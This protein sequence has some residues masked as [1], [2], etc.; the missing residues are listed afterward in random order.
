[1]AV[2]KAGG[3]WCSNTHQ[4]NEAGQVSIYQEIVEP[5]L[6]VSFFPAFIPEPPSFFTAIWMKFSIYIQQII[7]FYI[8][9]Q[10][11]ARIM[12]DRVGFCVTH[13][14]KISVHAQ[15]PVSANHDMVV[16][17]VVQN[18]EDAVLEEVWVVSLR[19]CIY[20]IRNN[21]DI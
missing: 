19:R 12:S 15:V 6:F 18:R 4:L 9:M 16:F 8:F 20:S 3:E 2:I 21:N 13:V 1:M 10:F 11:V 17:S 7:H 5:S 14:V